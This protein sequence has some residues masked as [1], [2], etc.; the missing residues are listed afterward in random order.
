MNDETVRTEP[1]FWFESHPWLALTALDRE[2]DIVE[3]EILYAL[4]ELRFC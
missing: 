4:D 1:D 2:E 3:E